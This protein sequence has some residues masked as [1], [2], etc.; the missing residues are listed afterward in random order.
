MT[1]KQKSLTVCN[2]NL[3]FAYQSMIYHPWFNAC[4]KSL[5]LITNLVLLVYWG[6]INLL[7]KQE[8]HD[9][10]GNIS[11]EQHKICDQICD[12]LLVPLERTEARVFSSPLHAF[13]RFPSLQSNSSALTSP[14]QD[15]LGNKSL[16]FWKY[17]LQ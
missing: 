15:M 4:E 13:P 14:N 10:K 9:S 2:G 7:G 6:N 11:Y 8:S 16:L 12:Q 17:L 5:Q 1:V 3:A